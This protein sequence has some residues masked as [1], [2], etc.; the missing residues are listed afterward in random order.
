MNNIEPYSIPKKTY[1]AIHAWVRRNK[2]KPKEC[3]KC[4]ISGKAIW[5]A[6]VSKEYKRDL[7]DYV[8]LCCPCH[9]KM[10][11]TDEWRNKV[12]MATKGA[13]NP[14]YGKHHTDKTKETL[15]KNGSLRVFERDDRGSY[16]KFIKNLYDNTPNTDTRRR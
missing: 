6:N 14:F 4:G 3:S 16:K 9:R 7:S 2:P 12:S 15:R 13:N 10:D 8:P 1:W 11:Y 5:W